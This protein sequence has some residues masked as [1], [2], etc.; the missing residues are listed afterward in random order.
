MQFWALNEEKFLHVASSPWGSG[1]TPRGPRDPYFGVFTPP[2][3]WGQD[4]CLGPHQQRVAKAR[5]ATLRGES[6]Q[7]GRL[8]PGFPGSIVALKL[9]WILQPQGWILPASSVSLGEGTAGTPDRWE[10]SPRHT[11]TEVLPETQLSQDPWCTETVT[12]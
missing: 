5:D 11:L 2:L 6:H 1:Q 4:L 7:D 9:P 3:A 8:H 10:V 12:Q